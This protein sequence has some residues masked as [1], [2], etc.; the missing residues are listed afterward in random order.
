MRKNK[1]IQS[2]LPYLIYAA[3]FSRQPLVRNLGHPHQNE[4]GLYLF[5][6]RRIGT[7]HLLQ[8]GVSCFVSST[9]CSFGS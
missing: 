8:K 2:G 9:V 1:E 3:I 6:I 7:L 4:F 5:S